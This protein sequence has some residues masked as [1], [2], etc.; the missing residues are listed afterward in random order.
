MQFIGHTQPKLLI[1]E[2]GKHIRDINDIYAPEH[3]DEK[4]GELIPEHVL[5]YSTVIFLAEQ[6]NNLEECKELYIEEE[7]K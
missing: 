2:E 4:T 3:I 7:I 5:Y 6:I 1:A